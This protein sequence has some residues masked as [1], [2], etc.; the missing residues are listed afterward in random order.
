MA[1]ALRL[2]LIRPCMLSGAFERSS[3]VL[4]INLTQAFLAGDARQQVSPSRDFRAQNHTN[5]TVLYLVS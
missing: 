2:A 5:A 3:M 4:P 1:P